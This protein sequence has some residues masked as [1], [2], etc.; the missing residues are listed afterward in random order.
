[1]NLAENSNSRD[2]PRPEFLW[3]NHRTKKKKK[4]L[5]VDVVSA[6]VAAREKPDA[7]Y[8]IRQYDIHEASH[9][10]AIGLRITFHCVT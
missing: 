2:A 6:H 4:K 1:M 8:G 9:E 10:T 5:E 7:T 3:T